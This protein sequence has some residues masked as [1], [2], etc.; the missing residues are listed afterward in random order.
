MAITCGHNV[1]VQTKKFKDIEK[2]YFFRSAHLI[3][4]SPCL[5]VLCFVL[6]FLLS[7]L[8]LVP[9]PVLWVSPPAHNL[10]IISSQTAHELYGRRLYCI[11][12]CSDEDFTV[13]FPHCFSI[14][15]FSLF[16][17][18]SAQIFSHLIRSFVSELLV[19]TLLII[20]S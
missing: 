6:L 2:S 4:S 3:F 5:F 10:L 15:F 8:L 14:H 13:S 9:L 11:R 18:I 19:L 1:Y 17:F 7:T 16:L 12:S 20:C